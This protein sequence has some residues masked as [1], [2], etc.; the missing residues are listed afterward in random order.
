M[1]SN[2]KRRPVNALSAVFVRTVKYAGKYAD[3]NGLRLIVAPS[4]ARR[5]EQRIAI[6]GKRVDLGLGG[7][8]LVSLQEAREQA[9][10]NRKSARAGGDPLAERR[11]HEMPTFAE[12]AEHVIAFNRPTWR[13]VKHAAQWSSTLKTYASPRLGSR[14]V[15]EI[16]KADVLGVLTPIW[17]AK[18]E[19][20]RRVRQRIGAVM[21]WAVAQGYRDDNPAGE[22]LSAVL[23]KTAKTRAHQRAIA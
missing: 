9:L 3:G 11:Q 12:A 10:A 16:T 5:W 23:P 14:L 20:A 6:R 4:G 19:T 1:M 21:D 17:T 8:P 18:P 2:V 7:Y 15:G 22:A 13:N